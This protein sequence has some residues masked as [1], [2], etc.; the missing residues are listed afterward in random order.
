MLKILKKIIFLKYYI[1]YSTA[2]IKKRNG[3]EIQNITLGNL[4]FSR[5]FILF[6]NNQKIIVLIVYIQ[7]V[8]SHLILKKNRRN[9]FSFNIF[10]IIFLYKKGNIKFEVKR[11]NIPFIIKII[12]KIVY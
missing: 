1:C 2:Y 4:I 12:V 11:K 8:G 10:V 9:S 7:F 3:I 5:V 6:Q